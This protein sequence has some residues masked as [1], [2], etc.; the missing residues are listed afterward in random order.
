MKLF[1]WDFDDF[2]IREIILPVDIV[3]TFF[4]GMRILV[5]EWI[6]VTIREDI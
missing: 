3:S 6:F 2:V 5:R 4:I 1:T